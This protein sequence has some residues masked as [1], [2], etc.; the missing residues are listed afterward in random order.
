[1]V[2]Q[3]KNNGVLVAHQFTL[4]VN[5]GDVAS[6]CAP[7]IDHQPSTMGYCLYHPPENP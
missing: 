3:R 1:M 2:D 6:R 7:T 5:H 4:R